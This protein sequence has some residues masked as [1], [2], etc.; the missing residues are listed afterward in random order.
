MFL[1][2]LLIA[3]GTWLLSWSDHV[4]KELLVKVYFASGATPQQEAFVGQRLR[5]D[6]RA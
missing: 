4:K 6:T 5:H 1:L 2:G 3:L